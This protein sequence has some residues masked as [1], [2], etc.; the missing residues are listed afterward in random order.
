MITDPNRFHSTEK[1][2]FSTRQD[3]IVEWMHESWATCPEQLI[4]TARVKVAIQD[5]V[6][7][8]SET[9]NS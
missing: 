5:S 8:S 7:E 6:A 4:A 9:R 3:V 2:S 1:L